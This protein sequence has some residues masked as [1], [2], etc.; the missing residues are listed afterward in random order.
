[1]LVLHGGIGFGQW[2]STPSQRPDIDWL[3]YKGNLR[4]IRDTEPR[5]ASVAGANKARWTHLHNIVWSDP[6]EQSRGPSEWRPHYMDNARGGVEVDERGQ[7]LENP[8]KSFNSC[9]TQCFCERNHISMIIRSHEV[10]ESGYE[11]Q[12][13]GRLCTVF[14]ARNYAKMYKND[15]ALVLLQPDEKGR[16]HCKFKTLSHLE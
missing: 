4:P 1:V 7:V 6:M 12:H 2:S 9:W 3:E 15:A 16:L 11:L 13:N 10:K 14:S 8:I 5:R